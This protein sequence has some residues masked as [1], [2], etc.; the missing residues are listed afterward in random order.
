MDRKS[1]IIL[2]SE[3]LDF[4]LKRHLVQTLN[5][6]SEYFSQEHFER[7]S[8]P[9]SF[10]NMMR[11]RAKMASR[12][13]ALIETGEIQ[14]T[15]GVDK[16]LSFGHRFDE[17]R[18]RVVPIIVIPISCVFDSSAIKPMILGTNFLPGMISRYRRLKAVGAIRND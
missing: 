14:V 10:R 5:D 2:E 18:E 7:K 16:G 17:Y 1:G 13:K 3:V 11:V 9:E 6:F 8:H 4:Q 12:V 15:V